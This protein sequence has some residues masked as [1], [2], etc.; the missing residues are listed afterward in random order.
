MAFINVFISNPATIVVENNKLVVRGDK[1]AK[2]AIA[3]INTVLIESRNCIISSY[4]LS[5]LVENKS[6]V[7]ICDSKHIPNGY[8]LPYNSYYRKLATLEKQLSMSKPLKKQL[9]QSIVKQK[10]ANQA[11]VLG[12]QRKTDKQK[13][14]ISLRKRVQSNDATNLEASA[15][16]I[17]FRALFG[18][19][20]T[21]IREN[22]INSILNYGYTII[23]GLIARNIAVLGFEPSIGIFHC[24]KLNPFNLADDLIEPFRP[25]VD[26]LACTLVAKSSQ[27]CLTP[28]IKKEIYNLIN[29]DVLINEQRH[30]LFYA[31]ELNVSS[32]LRSVDNKEDALCLPSILPIK[33]HEYE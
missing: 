23:R 16:N 13:K 15:A 24:N 6:L 22:L 9:W 10:I 8:I 18:D 33:V 21:R 28:S 25:I 1:E 3:D 12:Y 14:L 17:Y 32:L 30:A 4:A 7:Y 2:F 5:K 29:C 27:D 26:L 11:S 20:F 19:S 31:I